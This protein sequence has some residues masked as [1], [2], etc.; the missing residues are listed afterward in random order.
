M[1]NSEI[2]SQHFCVRCKPDINLEREREGQALHTTPAEFKQSSSLF[3]G[4]HVSFL[5]TAE[6]TGLKKNSEE[7]HADHW[8]ATQRDQRY[9]KPF[10]TQ[11]EKE[12]NEN[13]ADSHL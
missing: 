5:A 11:Q 7:I 10:V 2:H 1:A 3:I 8:T 13:L 6:E 12:K 9:I 4:L